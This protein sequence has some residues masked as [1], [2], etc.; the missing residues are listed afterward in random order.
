MRYILISESD[1]NYDVDAKEFE[2]EREAVT[3]AEGMWASMSSHDKKHS[4]AFY[5]LE[6]VN[7]D[8]DAEDHFDGNPVWEAKC[9]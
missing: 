7:P 2:T 6:S 9:E 3:F 4:T 1:L 5:V 8:V